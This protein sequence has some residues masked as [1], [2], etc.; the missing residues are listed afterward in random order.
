MNASWHPF[1][2]PVV[3]SQRSFLSLYPKSIFMFTSNI[4]FYIFFILTK[5]WALLVHDDENN[6]AAAWRSPLVPS[7]QDF[8]LNIKKGKKK[9]TEKN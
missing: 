1:K 4:F 3:E 8:F 5:V 2:S 9:K 7:R 6:I